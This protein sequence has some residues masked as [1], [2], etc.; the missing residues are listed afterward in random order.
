M[1][2][3]FRLPKC[4]LNQLVSYV[5]NDQI[6][7]KRRALLILLLLQ[8]S[9]MFVLLIDCLFAINIKVKVKNQEFFYYFSY[10]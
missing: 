2:F 5:M 8:P 7:R 10:R 4:L 1:H 3:L 6:K 9:I